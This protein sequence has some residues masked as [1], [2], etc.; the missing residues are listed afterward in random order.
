MSGISSALVVDSCVRQLQDSSHSI[1][2]V[3]MSSPTFIIGTLRGVGGGGVR[4]LNG[5]KE[6]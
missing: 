1:G 2:H 5:H 3:K 6:V 4:G